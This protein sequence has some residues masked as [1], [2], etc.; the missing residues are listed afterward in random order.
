MTSELLAGT[1]GTLALR[2][3]LA[4]AIFGV[5]TSTV[6]L[7]L[8]FVAAARHMLRARAAQ[9]VIDAVP[10]ESLPPVTI[11]KPIHNAEQE[12]AANLESFFRQNYPNF[13]VVFGVRDTENPAYQ[14]ARDVC[15]RYPGVPSRIVISGPPVW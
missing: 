5:F 6:Y 4:L 10:D 1:A 8:T 15:A 9:A 11:L 14:V 7:L 12:L 2:A 13:E 3:L